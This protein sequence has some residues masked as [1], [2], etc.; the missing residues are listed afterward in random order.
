MQIKIIHTFDGVRHILKL[1][2][3]DISTDECVE[4]VMNKITNGI[5]VPE[6]KNIIIKEIQEGL[7]Y[8][9]EFNMRVASKFNMHGGDFKQFEIAILCGSWTKVPKFMEPINFQ[10]NN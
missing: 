7:Q 1:K 10:T 8:H 9:T 2:Q 4:G 3:K 5:F 6:L